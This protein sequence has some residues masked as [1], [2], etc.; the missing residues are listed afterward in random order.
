MC[1]CRQRIEKLLLERALEQFPESEDHKASLEGYAFVF[2]N[3]IQGPITTK[4]Y[5]PALITH[6]VESKQGNKRTKK[7]K[8]NF[9]FTYCPFCGE[10]IE[11][12]N[13][14]VES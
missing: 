11:T 3:G 7:E 2:G 13:K 1:E 4:P 6:L 10:K 14:E 8:L 5:M 12:E 9:T